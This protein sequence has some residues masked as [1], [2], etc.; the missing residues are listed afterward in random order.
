MGSDANLKVLN[1]SWHKGGFD[2]V[3]ILNVTI[4]N[5]SKSFIDDIQYDTVYT[6]ET[7]ETV[8]K[9]G[10]HQLFGVKDVKKVVLPGQTRTLEINDG[11]IDTE[12]VRVTFQITGYKLL[13]Q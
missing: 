9:G 11:F 6:A 7:G 8:T 12:A 5:L 2:T 3:S 4:K 10:A 13:D 1:V